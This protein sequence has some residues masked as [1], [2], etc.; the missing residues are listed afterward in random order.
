MVSTT[1]HSRHVL[2]R[3]VSLAI[4]VNAAVGEKEVSLQE[5]RSGFEFVLELLGIVLRGGHLY[6]AWTRT[7]QIRIEFKFMVPEL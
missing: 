2:N 3:N 6:G 7:V 1:I 4:Q 5:I